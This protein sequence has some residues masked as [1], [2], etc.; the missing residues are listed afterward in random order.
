MEERGAIGLLAAFHRGKIRFDRSGYF[1]LLS[2]DQQEVIYLLAGVL[3]VADGLD[4]LHRS[5][6]RSFQCEV[7]DDKVICRVLASSDCSEE[8]SMAKEKAELL[9]Q[10]LGRPMQFIQD[11]DEQP[12]PDAPDAG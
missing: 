9:E 11:S 10:A 5:R 3:R 6:V 2:R 7:A 4:G 8:V 1:G 12:V